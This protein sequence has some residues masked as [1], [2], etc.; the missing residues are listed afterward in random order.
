MPDGV[1]EH[2]G[3]VATGTW[4]CQRMLGSVT[5]RAQT[6]GGLESAG[7]GSGAGAAAGSSA[8]GSVASLSSGA[9]RCRMPT[10]ER[11]CRTPTLP[12]AAAR[13]PTPQ[14]PLPER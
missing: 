13:T 14:K 12:N 10:L 9:S 8:G 1:N 5:Y 11:R 7:S 3:G 2:L 6:Y 4:R